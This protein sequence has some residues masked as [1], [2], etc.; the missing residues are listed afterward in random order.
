MTVAAMAQSNNATRKAFSDALDL[1]AQ[2]G[3]MSPTEAGAERDMLLW[4]STA[5][6]E[7]LA[8]RIAT[9]YGLGD[10]E[11]HWRE[12]DEFSVDLVR[13][14]LEEARACLESEPRQ[15]YQD[16]RQTV[17]MLRKM[18]VS[19]RNAARR[20]HVSVPRNK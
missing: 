6:A 2:L 3:K 8:F 4:R 9:I 16:V 10:Y 11:P 15:A 14:L 12:V 1:I 20:R 17:S 18:R 13:E 19:T 5:E 7:Y